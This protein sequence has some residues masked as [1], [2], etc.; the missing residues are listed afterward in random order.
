MLFAQAVSAAIQANEGVGSAGRD[1]ASGRR[2]MRA[3]GLRCDL[4][5]RLKQKN[6]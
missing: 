2:D 6:F 1:T 4:K 3:I 5:T